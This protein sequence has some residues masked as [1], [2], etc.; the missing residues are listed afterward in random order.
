MSIAAAALRV[1]VTVSA[2]GLYLLCVQF[3][4]TG[5]WRSVPGGPV[6]GFVMCVCCTCFW[7]HQPAHIPVFT[8]PTDLVISRTTYVPPSGAALSLV[9][10]IRA[11]T[12]DAANTFVYTIMPQSSTF[13]VQGDSLLFRNA[14]QRGNGLSVTIVSTDAASFYLARS[15]VVD[16]GTGVNMGVTSLNLSQTLFAHRE[17]CTDRCR[18]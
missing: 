12:T 4:G 1:P 10:T 7:F 5:P 13:T 18:H 2:P 3:A 17:R 9:A 14:G 8:P 6:A 15:F 16:E 11:L